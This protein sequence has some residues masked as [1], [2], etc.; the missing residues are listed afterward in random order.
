MWQ[1]VRRP[2]RPLTYAAMRAVVQRANEKLGTNWSLHDVRHTAAKRMVADPKLSLVDVQWV[3]G[4]AHVTTTQIY[5]EPV[6]EEVVE[7]MLIHHRARAT[8]E[9]TPPVPA[10]GYRPEVLATLLGTPR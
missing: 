8:A 5:T 1:T 6:A 7:R 4:H 2:Y 9:S 10:P 3:M